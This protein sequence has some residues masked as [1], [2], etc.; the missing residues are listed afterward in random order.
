MSKNFLQISALILAAWTVGFGPV[1]ADEPCRKDKEYIDDHGK[2][3]DSDC[4]WDPDGKNCYSTWTYAAVKSSI[5][6]CQHYTTKWNE[7]SCY[8]Q[9]PGAVQ[10][11]ANAKKK[12]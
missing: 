9:L 7:D 1:N 11:P 5:G 10:K 8:C 2:L 12:K 6:S 4:Q 3:Q